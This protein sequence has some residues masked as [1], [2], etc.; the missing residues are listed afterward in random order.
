MKGEK[1][2]GGKE[3]GHRRGS[4]DGERGG[5]GERGEGESRR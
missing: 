2:G 5:L 4:R 1:G 3:G